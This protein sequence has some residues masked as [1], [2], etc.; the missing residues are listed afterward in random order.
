MAI[1]DFLDKETKAVDTL[2]ITPAQRAACTKMLETYKETQSELSLDESNQIHK[3]RADYAVQILQEL[4][5]NGQIDTRAFADA[6]RIKNNYDPK[7]NFQTACR[8]LERF[9]ESLS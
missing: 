8:E 7:G 2:S 9:I 6:S 4:L 5:K 3:L 1:E